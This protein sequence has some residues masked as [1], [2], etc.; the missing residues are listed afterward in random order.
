MK[1]AEI[2]ANI[3]P[4]HVIFVVE[5]TANMVAH[6]EVLKRQ[7]MRSI[8]QQFE[9]ES[10][11]SKP[12][13]SNLATPTQFVL[14]V[15]HSADKI[16]HETTECFLPVT[17]S[18][19]FLELLD[20]IAY[21][22]GATE[23]HAHI[24]NGLTTALQCFSDLQES[25]AIADKYLFLLSNSLPY[26]RSFLDDSSISD[27]GEKI[28][29]EGIKI[30]IMCPRHINDLRSLFVTATRQTSKLYNY[31]WDRRQLVLL[32]TGLKVPS[33]FKEPTLLTDVGDNSGAEFSAE[34]QFSNNGVPKIVHDEMMMS[35]QPNIIQYTKPDPDR[36]NKPPQLPSQQPNQMIRTSAAGQTTSAPPQI[37]GQG[38]EKYE[39][40]LKTANTI[41]EAAS[42]KYTTHGVIWQ[43][44][45]EWHERSQNAKII[46]SAECQIRQQVAPNNPKLTTIN[47]LPKLQIAFVPNNLLDQIKDR[48][49]IK[50]TIVFQ[51]ANAALGSLLAKNFNNQ[52]GV[53]TLVQ[54]TQAEESKHCFLKLIKQNNK[55]VFQ[56]QL[57]HKSVELLSAMREIMQVTKMN[58]A[59]GNHGNQSRVLGRPMLGS[60]QAQHVIRQ[61][62]HTNMHQQMLNQQQRN[63][64]TTMQQQQQQAG[65]SMM[66]KPMQQQ[67]HI[68]SSP[69]VISNNQPVRII[70]QQQATGMTSQQITQMNQQRQQQQANR[71]QQ[72]Y[73]Q[74]QQQQQHSNMMQRFIKDAF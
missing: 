15:F 1:P 46:K 70:N 25:D 10:T 66:G 5:G 12:E 35:R 36:V 17:T 73:Q 54:R 52:F 21:T 34:S 48:V 58:A 40:A 22:G 9:K 28:Y 20:S 14:V 45:I 30:S 57:P 64:M 29:K 62:Q 19:E 61:Q 56:G 68:M 26:Q 4:K 41:L 63:K 37:P 23:S 8:V 18:R 71:Q 42:N 51:L 65:N 72:I 59:A 38:Q 27:I 24:G 60:N 2:K 33:D 44:L 55:F 43:G 32:S 47:W 31:A 13:L 39:K 53:V 49:V 6:E 74:Q 67:Q 50:A 3:T 16:G 7:Y 11:G 69:S